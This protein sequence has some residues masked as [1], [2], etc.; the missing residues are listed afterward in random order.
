MLIWAAYRLARGTSSSDGFELVFV[1][2]F[3]LWG[4]L[5]SVVVRK[6]SG[7]AVGWIL[8]WLGAVAGVTMSTEVLG[9]G[10]GVADNEWRSALAWM[11]AWMGDTVPPFLITMLLLYFPAGLLRTRLE[12]VTAALAIFVYGFG[13]VTI[14]FAPG[15]LPGHSFENPFGIE[16]F[17]R[18]AGIGDD[19]F[20]DGPGLLIVFVLA[21]STIVVRFKRSRG[22]ERQQMKWLVLAASG[23]LL[24]LIAGFIAPSGAEARTAEAVSG[25]LFV[26]VFAGFAVAIAIAILRYRL[27][28]IDLVINRAL[29][30]S[31]L[32]AVLV[33]VYVALVFGLQSVMAPFTAESDLAIAGSTL[34]V[35]ALFRPLRSR[36]QGLIDR[37]FY[38][39]KFDAQRTLEDFNEHLRDE[40]D[41]GALSSR[42]ELVVSETMQPAHVSLWLRGGAS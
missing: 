29:V 32:T 3:L 24:L 2:V 20:A 31:V 11:G 23:L 30:Y 4:V 13:A 16:A 22:D 14:A 18:L 17:E 28:D 8:L 15:R 1:A 37:R 12:R 35:A 5:G 42:L 33:G 21:M 6:T 41:L 7:H 34:A 25:V 10:A 9:A 39:R 19:V 40:V 38:R 26:L 36:V 27:Y